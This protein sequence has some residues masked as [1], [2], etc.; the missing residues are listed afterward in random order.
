MRRIDAFGRLPARGVLALLLC[1]GLGAQA[2]VVDGLVGHWTFDNGG[3]L[4]T[5]SSGYG[6]DGAVLGDTAPTAGVVGG[7]ALFDGNA[8]YIRVPDSA[9][10][11]TAAGAGLDRTV[12]F[13]FK[14]ATSQNRVVLE[15]GGNQHMVVQ[16]ESVTTPPGLISWRVNGPNANRV[17][18]LD[19]VDDGAWHHY[20]ATY[21][22]ANNRM[23]LAIDGVSQG[24]SI[25]ASS[26]ANNS[27][28]VIGAR[29]G[30]GFGF[31]G[32]MDD[33]AIWN[34]RLSG[35]E[36]AAIYEAGSQGSSLSGATTRE[37]TAYT[38]AMLEDNPRFYWSFNEPGATDN[39]VDL[40]RRQAS[41]QLVARG[42]AYR[43][44]S[45][46]TNLGAAAAF[47][48]ND[49]FTAT[50][51]DD[52]PPN[53]NGMPGAW[54]VEMW[55]KP[56]GS[57]AGSRGD[58][59]LNAGNNNPAFIYDYGVGGDNKVGLFGGG[60]RTDP[61]GP[62]IDDNGWH[63]LVATFYGNGAG[64]GVA[65]RVD[66]A[67]DGVVTT[68]PRGGFSSGFD[69]GLTAAQ[70]LVI[71]GA[72]AD[73]HASMFEGKIDEV[74]LYDLSGLTEA[75]VAARTTQIAGH[76]LLASGSPGTPLRYAEGVTYQISP[77]TPT[78]GGA[79]ADPG[80]TKLVDGVIGSTGGAEW[81]TGEWVGWS[82]TDPV[83]TFDLGEAWPLDALF[84]DYLVSHRVGIYAPDGLLV[85][86][87]ND[88]V[89]F[90][91]VDAILTASFNDFDPTPTAF[92]AWNRRTVVDLEGTV[93]RYVRLSTTNDMQWTFL[94][95]A[96]FVQVIPEPGTVVLLA[97]GGLAL[98][99]R[100]RR[101]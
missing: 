38:W 64:F 87:S 18:S 89:D 25:Q 11:D 57:L 92:N 93:A 36:I 7:A 97:M 86:F 20:V 32:S 3:A 44:A 54:A 55:V 71:G 83:V 31:P 9:S 62:S 21:H 1:V 23:E 63:H 30:G 10:L 16:T 39:A 70:Q 80:Q 29:D 24:S 79:Y 74:A 45:G 85:E 52:N 81:G 68:V 33:V 67:L 72:F 58:Y 91:S 61:G 28:V 34:R 77:S 35:A 12:A 90:A 42:D 41:D 8:D 51:M 26:G 82:Y 53:S 98:L 73:G 100:R 15:K 60:G 40:V 65:D 99:R 49:S 27:P 96:Q 95:E 69:L 5:D 46:S 17:T 14:T 59:L 4:G 22:G 78:G 50:N 88:G 47:D 56:D 2:G 76:Y 75:Q 43:S 66:V 84:L 6:N 19:R 48:G 101:A 37:Y 13:W 94:G